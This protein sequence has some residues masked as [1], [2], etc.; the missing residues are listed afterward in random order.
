MKACV[1]GQIIIVFCLFLLG[2]HMYADEQE[3]AVSETHTD[4]SEEVI[5][6]VITS[7]PH[8][9]I[10]I[11]STYCGISPLTTKVAAPG[12]YTIE[13][14]LHKHL[15]T[16]YISVIDEK[17]TEINLK[18]PP[19][20]LNIVAFIILLGMSVISI[21]VFGRVKTKEAKYSSIERMYSKK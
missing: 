13:A 14:R 2:F 17:I 7:P 20:P 9:K 5:L 3:D 1:K 19:E 8:A 4:L 12:S 16:A 18:F 21:I 15:T 10:Y 11:N 6:K